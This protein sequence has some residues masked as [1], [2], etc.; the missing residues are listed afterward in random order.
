MRKGEMAI[1]LL[2]LDVLKWAIYDIIKAFYVFTSNYNSLQF[3][4]YPSKSLQHQLCVLF[5]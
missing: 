1:F 4:E 3:T 5:M 2:N